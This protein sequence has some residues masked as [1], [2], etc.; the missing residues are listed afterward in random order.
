MSIF[1]VVNK[2][3][4]KQ[5]LLHYT[6]QAVGEGIIALWF[7]LNGAVVVVVVVVVVFTIAV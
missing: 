6:S 2:T 5:I 3:K 4:Q 1:V 7:L